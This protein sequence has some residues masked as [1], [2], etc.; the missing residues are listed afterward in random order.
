MYIQGDLREPK[1]KNKNPKIDLRGPNNTT[2]LFYNFIRFD[3][4]NNQEVYTV[5]RTFQPSNKVRKKK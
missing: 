2:F 1:I 5:K 4:N 3:I